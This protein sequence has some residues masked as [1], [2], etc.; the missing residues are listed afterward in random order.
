VITR[1]LQGVVRITVLRALRVRASYDPATVAA[2]AAG[3][4]IVCCNHVS[5]ADG[6]IVALASPVPLAFGVEAEFSRRNPLT[7]AGLN[8]LAAFGFGSI[9]PIDS[10]SPFGIR[11]LA[12]ELSAGRS[13]M[14]FP[15]GRISPTGKQQELRPG[16]TW[17][18]N[19]C[20]ARIRW[21]S[22]RG[23]ER[24]RLFA[25]AGSHWWP[26]IQIRFG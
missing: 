16:I 22:I 12:A 26:A 9:V 17:L 3:R 24:S 20:S 2:I 25:K 7:R 23:A 15:E 1:A 14:L 10:S 11:R 21:I 19:R 8:M 4:T 6:I 18:A 5:F 13:V